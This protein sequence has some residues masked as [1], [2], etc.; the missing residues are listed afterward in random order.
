MLIKPEAL[1]QRGI[2]VIGKQAD[3]DYMDMD[4][5][6]LPSVDNRLIDAIKT[7]PGF[8]EV[9]AYAGPER[10]W[11]DETRAS[12]ASMQMMFSDA[13]KLAAVLYVDPALSGPVISWVNADS[14]ADAL[15]E[16]TKEMHA[17]GASPVA[18]FDPPRPS[19]K[20]H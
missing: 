13:L 18:S 15:H 19:R 14:P 16:W 7:K 8:L 11:G 6:A 5:V 4:E 1:R 12:G 9:Y 20:G 17:G 3:G 2:L 10:F